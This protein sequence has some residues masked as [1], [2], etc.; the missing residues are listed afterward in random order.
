MN[1]K[2]R[3]IDALASEILLNGMK[4]FEERFPDGTDEDFMFLYSCIHNRTGLT[5]YKWEQEKFLKNT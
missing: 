5:L 2:G 1:I 4:L 3:K